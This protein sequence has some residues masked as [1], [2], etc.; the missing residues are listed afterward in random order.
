MI[1]NNCFLGE[2]PWT[3]TYNS[4]E[5]RSGLGN[6]QK[7]YIIND[8]KNDYWDSVLTKSDVSASYDRMSEVEQ[9]LEKLNRIF[10]QT[11]GQNI[12]QLAET[13]SQMVGS[14]AYN[15]EEVG[16]SLQNLSTALTGALANEKSVKPNQKDDLE[17]VDQIVGKYKNVKIS[18]DEDCA[19]WLDDLG[20]PV[21]DSNYNIRPIEDVMD[22]I[23]GVWYE[24]TPNQKYRTTKLLAGDDAMKLYDILNKKSAAAGEPVGNL[25]DCVGDPAE[26]VVDP[27]QISNYEIAIEDFDFDS[28]LNKNVPNVL[29]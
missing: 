28:W 11:T 2:E 9:T 16:K 7:Y 13:I 20:I 17:K 27:A 25:A 19:S 29:I 21:Y 8:D 6:N 18:I 4:D 1:I 14:Y 3:V 12:E 5:A 26:P 24:L 22:F 10:K 15:A 23:A